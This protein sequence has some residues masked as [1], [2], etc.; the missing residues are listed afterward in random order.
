MTRVVVNS[1][2][3]GMIV[4]IE[5]TKTSRRRF[6]IE[7]TTDCEMLTKMGESL[8]EVDQKDVLKPQIHSKIYQCASECRIHT[9]CP[10][11]MAILKA[12]EVEAGLALPRP[13]TVHFQPSP[14][15]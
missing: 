5:V 12:I 4:T 2:V 11:P 1:G 8:V 14:L 9:S 10:I 15:A 7:V 3:C 6:R 13:V